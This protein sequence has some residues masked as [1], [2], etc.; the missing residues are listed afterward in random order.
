MDDP[1]IQLSDKIMLQADFINNRFVGTTSFILRKKKDTLE[2][3]PVNVWPLKL[4]SGLI[5]QFDSTF[6]FMGK[7]SERDR[8]QL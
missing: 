2:A 1:Y 4:Q 6:I 7:I 8:V 5:D 3:C